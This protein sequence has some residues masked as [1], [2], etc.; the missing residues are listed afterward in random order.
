MCDLFDQAGIPV[1][2]VGL[3][4]SEGLLSGRDIVAG[5]FHPSFRELME[6][7]RWR[8]RLENNIPPDTAHYLEVHTAQKQVPFAAGH[9]ASNRKWLLQRFNEVKFVP[10][11]KLTGNDFY[12]VY[13]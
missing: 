9:G 5:P 13:H 11:H 7:Y 8:K 10:D 6:T 1:I 4:P 2:R 12:V 3:H